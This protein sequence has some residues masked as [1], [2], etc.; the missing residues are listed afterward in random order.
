MLSDFLSEQA[1]STVSHEY[2]QKP[3]IVRHLRNTC[4][5]TFELNVLPQLLLASA[6]GYG[7]ATMVVA[8]V[9]DPVAGFE[10]AGPASLAHLGDAAGSVTPRIEVG[11]GGIS[12]VHARGYACELHPK[13]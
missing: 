11:Y 13:E 4:I 9:P 7:T 5:P 1:H 6:I 8:A 3:Y 2:N 12:R 10:L